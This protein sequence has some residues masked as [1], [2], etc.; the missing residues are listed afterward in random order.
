MTDPRKSKIEFTA[1]N[2]EN[3]KIVRPLYFNRQ[4]KIPQV[5]VLHRCGDKQV[6]WRSEVGN[7]GVAG[8]ER[9]INE[10]WPVTLTT[11]TQSLSSGQ[12]LIGLVPA[13]VRRVAFYANDGLQNFALPTARSFGA[14]A[15]LISDVAQAVPVI[16][17]AYAE[18]GQP[19]EVCFFGHGCEWGMT[20]VQANRAPLLAPMAG[21]VRGVW[22]LGC[23][24]GS[25]GCGLMRALAEHVRAP[26]YGASTTI[27]MNGSSVYT[28]GGQFVTVRPE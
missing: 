12:P 23:A 28:Y 10:P 15:T 6:H 7:I 1:L 21:K 24:V 22:C 26:V 11:E 3:D 13:G 18:S 27:W 16:E 19:V 5:C 4:L 2:D 20:A 14:E 17:K 8:V 25:G 9:M